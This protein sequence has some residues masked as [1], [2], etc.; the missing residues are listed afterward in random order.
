MQ[1]DYVAQKL[2]FAMGSFYG[3]ILLAVP[4]ADRHN[5]EQLRKGFPWIVS[6]WEAWQESPDGEFE[7][8]D[9]PHG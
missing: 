6:A 2:G 5:R 8:I 3:Q 9:L 7:V 1:I 4:H